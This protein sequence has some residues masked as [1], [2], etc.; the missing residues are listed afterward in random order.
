MR[1]LFRLADWAERVSRALSWV[2]TAVAAVAVL[3]IVAVLVVASTQRY[4][5]THPIAATEELA[6][7]LFIVVSFC[8]V[9]G[10]F[11]ERR[12]IRVLPLWHRFPP[13][14][15]GW[16]ILLGHLAAIVV[17]VFLFQQTWDFALS[18]QRYGTRSYVA[19]LLEWPW[20]MVIPVSL[21]LLALVL[22]LRVVIDLVRIVRREQPPEAKRPEPQ[23]DEQTEAV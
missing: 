8:S 6:A 15:Q 14:L 19:D 3:G 16:S 12:H 10:G 21:G 5:L 11:V 13:R 4:L 7:Y 2:L 1:T 20:M 17:L 18:S 22:A 9:A 23:S